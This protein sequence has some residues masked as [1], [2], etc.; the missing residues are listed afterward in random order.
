MQNES[1]FV[2]LV[3]RD[4]RTRASTAQTHWLYIG[5]WGA[6]S[7]TPG[8][9]IQWARERRRCETSYRLWAMSMGV[10]HIRRA[11]LTPM[12]I[13]YGLHAFS[14]LRCPAAA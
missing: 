13:A 11:Y 9:N 7:R 4:N 1:D 3:A 14:H 12:L 2:T 6:Y 8:T 10:R 5:A